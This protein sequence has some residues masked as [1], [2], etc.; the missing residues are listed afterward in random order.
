[1]QQMTSRLVV[2]LAV[3]TM[4]TQGCGLF[5]ARD[6]AVDAL[7]MN[8][9]AERYVRLE[10]HMPPH[11]ANH[12]DAYFGPEEWKPAEEAEPKPLAE[13]VAEA[14]TVRSDLA[15]VDP[16]KGELER[17][18]QKALDGR[19]RAL[20]ARARLAAGEELPFDQ[21]TQALFDTS[22]PHYDR[23]HFDD[24]LADLDSLV[25][26]EGSLQE[27]VNSFRENF[28]IPSDRLDAVFSAAID[29]CRRRTLEYIELPASEDFT[30][31]Y[32]SDKPWSGYNWYQGD[33]SSLIEVNIDLPIRIDRA[34]D[35]GCHEGYPGHHTYKALLER[36]LAQG[37]GWVEFTIDP[38]YSPQS[39]IAEGSANYGVDL[40][41]PEEERLAFETEFLYPL[42]G[43]DTADAEAYQRMNEAVDKLSYAG[44]EAARRYL[45][46]EWSREQ[47][48]EW[49]ET[50]ALMDADRAAQRVDFMDTYRSYVI[51]YNWGKDL[52][53][54]YIEAG[55]PDT[56][57]KWTRF[58]RLLSMPLAASDLTEAR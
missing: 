49:L 25:P 40:A 10:L 23:Q 36:E 54:D 51:N 5:C 53:A 13:I 42:A 41:F 31:E 12:V 26:G 27:R 58:E 56:A 47:A 28:E 18:R 44:N 39:L 3:A 9:I 30:V 2:A 38:L 20:I 37:R 33:A 29:E 50:Y 55:D 32:V 24:I 14:E 19:L 6:A 35:L 21:E 48:I 15:E 11:D 8:D 4:V 16:G 46:G 45:D 57:E 34:V 52:V 17:L 7:T 22:A 43:L 1:M